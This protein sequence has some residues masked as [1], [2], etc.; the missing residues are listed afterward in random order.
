MLGEPIFKT[1]RALKHFIIEDRK[2]ANRLLKAAGVPTPF[3]DIHFYPLNEH[4]QQDEI[5]GIM[6]CLLEDNDMGMISGA[7]YPALADPGENVIKLAH[8][9]QI[10]VIPLYGASSVLLALAASGL[11]AEAFSFHAYLPAKNELRKG[12]IISL[13]KEA[14]Q[15]NYTQI[16]IETPYRAERLFED[17]LKYCPQNLFLCI[18]ADLCSEHETIRT[19]RIRDWKNEEINLRKRLV[20]FLLGK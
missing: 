4:S 6:N 9:H 20:V 3:K 15:T 12:V 14:E 11:N 10:K 8:H 18:A 2:P 19:K 5:T 16:F 17:L 13:A 7:G 1:I